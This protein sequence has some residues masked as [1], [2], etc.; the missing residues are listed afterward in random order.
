MCVLRCD[1]PHYVPDECCPLCD[2]KTC[3]KGGSDKRYYEQRH[4]PRGGK[5]GEK[6]NILNENLILSA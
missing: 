6:I 3:L 4:S 1:H 2:G 5:V